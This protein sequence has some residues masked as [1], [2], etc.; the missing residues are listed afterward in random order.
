[1][2]EGCWEEDIPAKSDSRCLV[3]R[4]DISIGDSI[5]VWRDQKRIWVHEGCAGGEIVIDI[6]EKFKSFVPSEHQE[7]IKDAYLN[8][9]SHIIIDAKAG[10]GKTTTLEWL[11]STTY[12]HPPKKILMMAF[13][14]SIAKELNNR[15]R[16]IPGVEA[17]TLNAYGYKLVLG[18]YG[19]PKEGIKSDKIKILAQRPGVGPDKNGFPFKKED[20][21][22]IGLTGQAQKDRIK[23]NRLMVKLFQKIIDMVKSNL[24]PPGEYED[25][26]ERYKIPVD[27]L[28]P[29]DYKILLETIPELLEANIKSAVDNDL[30]DFNDQIWLP[31]VGLYQVESGTPILSPAALSMLKP[32]RFPKKYNAIDTLFVDEAQDLNRSQQELALKTIG[33]NG[34]LIAVGDPFQSIYAFSGADS[35]SMSRL[36]KLLSPTNRGCNKMDLSVTFRCPKAVVRHAQQ[37]LQ[38]VIPAGVPVISADQATIEASDHAPEG[39]VTDAPE[40]AI[41]DNITVETDA[42]MRR[43]RKGGTHVPT[44]ILCRANAPIFGSALRLLGRGVPVKIVG[45]DISKTLI[46]YI[47]EINPKRNTNIERFVTALN[48]RLKNIHQIEQKLVDEGELD[49]EDDPLS[50]PFAQEKDQIVAIYILCC[51][52]P[53]GAPCVERVKTVKE[54]KDAID[55]LF[56]G[57]RCPKDRQHPRG[58][59]GFIADTSDEICPVCLAE[60]EEEV[61]IVKKTGVVFSTVHKSIGLEALKIYI[62]APDKLGAPRTNSTEEDQRQEIHL[63]Y[64]AA[65]RTKF[66]DGDADSGILTYLTD[67]KAPPPPQPYEDE[68][69]EPAPLPE[70]TVIAPE[71]APEPAQLPPPKGYFFFLDPE[72]TQPLMVKGKH[73]SK[74]SKKRARLVLASAEQLLKR[75][76]QPGNRLYASPDPGSEIKTPSEL[77]KAILPSLPTSGARGAQIPTMEDWQLIKASYLAAG[78]PAKIVMLPGNW[79][80]YALLVNGI[81]CATTTI[82]YGETVARAAGRKPIKVLQP[83]QYGKFF[84]KE[85]S[86]ILRTGGWKG[87]V[88]E[89]INQVIL[90]REAS[91]SEISN[92]EAMADISQNR[93]YFR[94]ARRNPYPRPNRRRWLRRRNMHY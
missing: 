80:Q 30:L 81:A 68:A 90:K 91:E 75:V 83:N 59:R 57:G 24:T 66:L 2:H 31:V 63:H 6:P 60:R 74:K 76:G 78:I 14:K 22:R 42:E 65:T 33:E 13:N 17:S 54:L 84:A 19:K 85:G 9:D 20:R 39:L 38:T 40:D 92:F 27:E 4:Q 5:I 25:L 48:S 34:R 1:V 93:R 71:I 3:C 52:G 62:L 15:V 23:R 89:R 87:R 51:G 69:P 18:A 49:L 37:I 36:F 61:A 21:H 70:P 86:K 8:S 32:V 64:V 73:F 72:L 79:Y 7:R 26:I 43:D 11:V 46:S 53:P 10:S 41:F 44:M 50:S 88:I 67:E 58:K 28:E 77:K 35:T 56:N 29:E 94:Y 16:A 45:R 82:N 47:D 12:K 55:E